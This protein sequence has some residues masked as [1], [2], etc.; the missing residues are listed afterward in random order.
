MKIIGRIF[1]VLGALFLCI[2]LACGAMFVLSRSFQREHEAFVRKFMADYSRHWDLADVHDRLS[3]E[4]L[5]QAQS[6]DGLQT[7]SL[8]RRLGDIRDVT[9]VSV[10]NFFVGPGGKSGV[11]VFKARFENA[12]A[13]VTLTLT[14]SAGELRV[15]GLNITPSGDSPLPA[16]NQ[17]H[18]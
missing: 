12:P 11:F 1:A 6:S 7:L 10:Q 9:D 2:V 17:S 13:L 16:S 15:R 14:E 4:F 5:E 3:T 18:L 8:F